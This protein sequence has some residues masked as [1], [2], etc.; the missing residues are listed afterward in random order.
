MHVV[1]N[2]ER[3]KYA[4]N[5]GIKWPIARPFPPP[6]GLGYGRFN[7]RNS[8][9]RFG[10]LDPVLAKAAGA[11]AQS[12]GTPSPSPPRRRG[13]SLDSRLRGN[14]GRCC[15][16]AFTARLKPGP[17]TGRFGVRR[18]DA[19]FPG[20]GWPCPAS[21]VES[22]RGTPS[23]SPPRRRG[24]RLDS[25]L[26][27]NDGRC[28]FHGSTA[29][30]KPGP[31]TKRFGVR[32]LAAAFPGQGLPCPDTR[33][34]VAQ[35]ASDCKFSHQNEPKVIENKA[36]HKKRTQERTRFYSLNWH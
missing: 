1:E 19:T 11:K 14:D 25:R 15:F 13:S 5:T 31:D 10:I 6:N 32:R 4:I 8:A 20:Q 12:R 26:R 2:K 24:S 36:H 3:L 29:R 34:S 17:D 35:R 27:G 16:P 30:L 7:T 23:P 33:R 18:L 28:Y 21:K 9:L 22:R